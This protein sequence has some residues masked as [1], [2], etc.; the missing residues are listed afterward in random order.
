LGRS[1][2][3]RRFAVDAE[4]PWNPARVGV[5]ALLTHAL[6]DEFS[7]IEEVKGQ[8]IHRCS[9]RPSPAAS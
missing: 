8:R 7:W 3:R 6:L 2:I 4:R 9:P 1:T 5:A